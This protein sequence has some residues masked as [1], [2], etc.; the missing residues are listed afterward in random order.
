MIL[1]VY[2]EDLTSDDIVGTA[3]VDLNKYMRSQG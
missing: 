1:T 3:S 2:D